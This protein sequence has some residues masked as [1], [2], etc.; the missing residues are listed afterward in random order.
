MAEG[1]AIIWKPEKRK[2]SDLKEW[3]KNPRIISDEKFE[4][5]AKQ[6]KEKGFTTPILINTDNTIIGGH[7]R[8]KALVE[9]GK[10]EEQI[11]VM[12][13]DRTLTEKE[14]EELALGD[15]LFIG[16]FDIDALQAN[17]ELGSLVDIGFQAWEVGG[18]DQNLLST[19]E[20]EEEISNEPESSSA[21]TYTPPAD[22]NQEESEGSTDEREPDQPVARY[23]FE[24]MLTA[25]ARER[26]YTALKDSLE[27]F[28][29]ENR[30][31]A[32]VRILDLY[33]A[34]KED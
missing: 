4:A 22:E 30:E 21:P 9:L 29:L 2:V 23:A 5:L 28:G 25:E 15:N 17:F 6:I 8:K 33:D 16:E 7:Q 19:T 27:R 20:E 24:I 14:F 32:L 31:E 34:H 26:F 13:P 10:S 18:V 1:K 3:E 12:V 11:Y